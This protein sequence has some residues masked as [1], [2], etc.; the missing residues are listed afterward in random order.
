MKSISVT[1]EDFEF[2]AARA[3]ALGCSLEEL[4]EQMVLRERVI[5]KAPKVNLDAPRTNIE[6]PHRKWGM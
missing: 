2:L 6:P 4:V 1:E 5:A 3:G